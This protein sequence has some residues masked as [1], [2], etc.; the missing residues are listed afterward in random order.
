MHGQQNIKILTLVHLLEG[1]EI[2]HLKGILLVTTQHS[3]VIMKG[4]WVG[5]RNITLTTVKFPNTMWCS[6]CIDLVGQNTWQFIV[7]QVVKLVNLDLC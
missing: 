6:E 5:G 1:I 7:R 2:G 3:Y 4:V